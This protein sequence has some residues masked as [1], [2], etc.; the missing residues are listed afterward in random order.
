MNSTVAIILG[1]VFVVLMGA[2]TVL[3]RRR[4]RDSAIP[5]PARGKGARTKAEARLEQ[6]DARFGGRR[7]RPPPPAERDRYVEN[8]RK[9]Q[10]EFAV[11][12]DSALGRADA[13]VNEV[14]SSCG[15]SI[16]DL[17][18]G[19]AGVAAEP[20]LLETY[21]AA[22]DITLRRARGEAGAE[23]LRE[24]LDHYRAL[25]EDLVGDI[26]PPPASAP[27]RVEARRVY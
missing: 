8:W 19:S 5:G 2:A 20:H 27:E 4:R 3:E 12:R 26:E 10:A 24:A 15:Y 16:G 18:A 7:R 6:L 14:M 13:L 25:F 17:G 22:H 21:Q 23:D 11:D 9:L 1:A